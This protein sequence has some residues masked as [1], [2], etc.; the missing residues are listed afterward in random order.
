MTTYRRQNTLVLKEEFKHAIELSIP[1][2]V[3][4][5]ER[6]DEGRRQDLTK[7][8]LITLGMSLPALDGI[9]INIINE[10]SQDLC[11]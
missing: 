1:L 7:A 10:V 9:L 11:C 4:K 6:P 2:N 5:D 3:T 8:P